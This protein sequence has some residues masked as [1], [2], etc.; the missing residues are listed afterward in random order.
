MN[1]DENDE[2][3][4]NQ[5]DEESGN[6]KVSHDYCSDSNRAVADSRRQNRHKRQVSSFLLVLYV[7]CSLD[8]ACG[9]R[10]RAL[11]ASGSTSTV[12]PAARIGCLFLHQDCCSAGI[13]PSL[14]PSIPRLPIDCIGSIDK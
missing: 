7:F 14:E 3:G 6:T 1:N 4:S 11:P 13:L 5:E 9:R 8:W 12:Y 2:V 10:L